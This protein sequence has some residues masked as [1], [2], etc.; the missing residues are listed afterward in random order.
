MML[1]E[2]VRVIDWGLGQVGPYA[3][4]LLGD[5]GAEVIKIEPPETGDF[6][7]RLDN[8]LGCSLWLADDHNTAFEAF[9]RNKKS[10]AVDLSK[11]EGRD[12]VRQLVERSDVLVTNYRAHAAAGLG[13]DYASL[14]QVNPRLI[15]A[16]ASCFGPEGPDAGKRGDDP[17]AQGRIGMMFSCSEPSDRPHFVSPGAGDAVTSMMLASAVQGAL[18]AREKSGIGQQV[19]VSQVS[20]LMALLRFQ[21]T[22]AFLHGY[23]NSEM[24]MPPD[25]PVTAHSGWFRC[26]DGKWI[27][28][29]AAWTGERGWREICHRIGQPQ[30]L[31]DPRFED[32][33]QRLANSAALKP[34]IEDALSTKTAEEWE[35]AF[36]GFEGNFSRIRDDLLEMADDAQMLANDYVVDDDHPVLGRI[37][38]IGV[39][40]DFSE[41]PG[42]VRMPP[43]EL[44]QHTE[45]VLLDVLGYDWQRIG[46]LKELQAII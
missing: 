24:K 28:M 30:L 8:F 6:M 11:S 31:D 22:M 2:D 12:V 15:Y 18:Y 44:G 13:L 45:E 25:D 43:P 16:H 37:K 17:T 3:A 7:R 42:A 32:I 29:S 33:H 1:L 21:V 46:E 14:R 27:F 40:P 20:T 41:T 36:A 19:T 38:T 34:I 5:L 35:S 10:V 39:L 4:M 23:K 9:N 26:K